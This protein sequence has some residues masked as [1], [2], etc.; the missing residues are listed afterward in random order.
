VAV[1]HRWPWLDVPER[2]GPWNTGMMPLSPHSVRDRS[3]TCAKN[4]LPVGQF[5]RG[6]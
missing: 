1:P 5:G 2:F 4:A 3:A 6:W